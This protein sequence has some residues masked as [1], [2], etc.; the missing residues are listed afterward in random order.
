[1]GWVEKR[2]D[3]NRIGEMIRERAGC[4]GGRGGKGTKWK[5]GMSANRRK[6]RV[7]Y[8]IEGENG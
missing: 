6:G 1:M 4:G 2:K 5:D 8:Y 3:N 7:Y